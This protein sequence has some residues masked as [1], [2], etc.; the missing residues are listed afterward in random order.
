MYIRTSSCND[1][2]DAINN[3]RDEETFRTTIDIGKFS[4][5]RLRDGKKNVGDN[6]DR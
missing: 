6:V 5:R 1:I 2:A 3:K 4:D